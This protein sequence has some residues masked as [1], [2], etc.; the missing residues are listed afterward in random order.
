MVVIDYYYYYYYY[1]VFYKVSVVSQGFG[2]LGLR[3]RVLDFLLGV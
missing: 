3:F 1:M 2:G